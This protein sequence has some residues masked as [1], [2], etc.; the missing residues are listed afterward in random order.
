MGMGGIVHAEVAGSLYT[1]ESRPVLVNC[2]VGLG[3]RV[4]TIDDL[5]TL[6]LDM[7][8]KM[9]EGKILEP[10]QWVGVRGLE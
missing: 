8:T 10:I 2:I 9:K 6:T 5:K 4:L 1:S 7:Y 3:G